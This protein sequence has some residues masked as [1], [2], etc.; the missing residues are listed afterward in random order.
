MRFAA[1][2]LIRCRVLFDGYDDSINIPCKGTKRMR[3]II[4][5]TGVEVF[6]TA[7]SN[8]L[9]QRAFRDHPAVDS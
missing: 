8:G 3:R 1:P 6:V 4:Q 5:S 7:S 2:V 9:R